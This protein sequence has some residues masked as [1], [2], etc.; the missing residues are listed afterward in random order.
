M[1]KYPLA[2]LGLIPLIYHA[3]VLYIAY[4]LPHHHANFWVWTLGWLAAAGS[5]GHY[6]YGRMANTINMVYGH[7]APD[8]TRLIT[9]HNGAFLFMVFILCLRYC[10]PSERTLWDDVRA[11]T[12]RLWSWAR[13]LTI[14]PHG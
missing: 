13:R 6:A 8:Y 7:V 11:D 5:A 1:G 4:R 10:F 2:W 14:R 9:A 12:R 3:V